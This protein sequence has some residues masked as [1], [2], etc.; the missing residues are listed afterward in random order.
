VGESAPTRLDDLPGVPPVRE[1]GEG[2]VASAQDS[3]IGAAF[4]EGRPTLSVVAP[5]YNEEANVLQWYTTLIEALEPLRLP[6]E[7]IAVD[8]GST[9]GTFA[10]LRALHLSDRRLHVI[11]FRRNFGQTAALSAGFDHA[12]GDVIVTMDA[13]LQNHAEDIPRLLKKLDEGYDI[14]SGWRVK[15][16]DAPLSRVLPSRIANFVISTVTGVKLHDYGCSLK[17]YRSDVAKGIRLYGEL[18]R[19]IPAIASWMG[20]EIAEI[21]VEHSPRRGGKSKYGIRRTPRVML[22]LVTVRFLLTFLTKPMQVFGLLGL[23]CGGAGGLLGLYLAYLKLI[24]G[25]DIGGRP[26]LLLCVLL[27]IVGVQFV[28]LG[29]IGEIITRVYYEVQ[30]KPIY[31]IRERLGWSHEK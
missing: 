29:L 23:T 27:V 24:L 31:V 3:A 19:F 22:D 12:R 26:L 30:G 20:T 10:E 15:R 28:V 13:D 14:V 6:F 5:L 2:A 18:H 9:D 1:V 16:Q 17:A 4:G 21:P 11:R 7:V 8:D 25:E